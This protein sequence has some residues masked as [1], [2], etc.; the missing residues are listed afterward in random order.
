MELANPD[1]IWITTPRLRLRLM[2]ESDRAE[3]TRVQTISAELHRPWT[4]IPP[5]GETLDEQFDSH[6]NRTIRGV[7]SG[8]EY[9]FV[10]LLERDRI[11]GFFNLFQIVRGAFENATA[12]W[13]IS[14]DVAGQGL[15]TEAVSAQLTIAFRDGRFGLNLHRVGA[16]VIPTNL[17]SLRV[18]EKAGFR[19][20]GLGVKYLR[21]AGQWQD[22]VLLAK[23][24]EE[25]LIPEAT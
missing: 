24:R 14:A 21:I 20:E 10:A 18:A 8:A 5:A 13:S 9:R 11:A 23:L 1:A 25:H 3:F 16:S 22:H 17:T 19:R 15:A 2:R 6:M 12:G 4:V 7:E